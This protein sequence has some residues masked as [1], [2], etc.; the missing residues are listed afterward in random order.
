MKIEMNLNE[1]P[2]NQIKNNLKTIELRL[3]YEKRKNIKLNDIILFTNVNTKEQITCKVIGLC[4]FNSFSEL[5]NITGKEK[6]GFNKE[7]DIDI[8]MTKYYP[9]DEIDKYGVLGIVISVI[10]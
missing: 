5:T 2:F 10:K 3:N 4:N 6:S 7:D 9:K 1:L 8:E